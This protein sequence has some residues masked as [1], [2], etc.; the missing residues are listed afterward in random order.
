MREK[1]EGTVKTLARIQLAEAESVSPGF[2][3]RIP[4]WTRCLFTVLVRQHAVFTNA[5]KRNSLAGTRNTRSTSLWADSVPQAQYMRQTAE[6][7]V[8]TPARIQLAG[9]KCVLPDNDARSSR[10]ATEVTPVRFW[11][12]CLSKRKEL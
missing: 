9:A 3:S 2:Q 8:Q 11:Y 4:A 1:A 5:G 12:R 10:A 7:D 6:G